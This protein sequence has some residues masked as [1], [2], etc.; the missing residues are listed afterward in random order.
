VLASPRKPTGAKRARL[1]GLG[2]PSAEKSGFNPVGDPLWILM[3]PGSYY[4]PPSVGQGLGVLQVSISI[5][6][7]LGLPVLR[8]R[9]WLLPMQ[10][11]A[12]PETAIHEDRAPL[13]REDDV[14][15]TPKCFDWTQV[16]SKPKSAAVE[17]AANQPLGLGVSGAIALHDQP[18]MGRGC[19]WR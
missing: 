1:L 8:V 14:C 19:S 7:N 3:L 11:T 9:N 5:A 16:L 4:K 13:R 17:K 10:R 15:G 6:A 2:P 12:V 18:G